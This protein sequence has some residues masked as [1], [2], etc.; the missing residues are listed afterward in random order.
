MNALHVETWW[1]LLVWMLALPVVVALGWRSATALGPAHR[2]LLVLVRVL[3]LGVVAAA[4]TRPALLSRSSEVSVVYALDVSSSVEPGFVEAAIAWMRRTNDQGQPAQARFVAFADRVREADAPESIRQL[5]LRLRGRGPVDG[6]DPLVTDLEGALDAIAGSFS[7]DRLRR[8]VLM[9]DGLETRGD[10]WRAV[11]RLRAANIR[12]FT[13][14]ASVRASSD[15]WVDAL[16]VPRDLRRDEPT[17]VHVRLRAQ[18]ATMARVSLERGERVLGQRRLRLDAGLNRVPFTI[19]LGETGAVSLTAR[20]VAEGDQIGDNDVLTANAT[21]LPRPRVLVIDPTTDSVRYLREALTAQG[22]DVDLAT[23]AGAPDSVE[24]LRPY[25]AVIVSD[26]NG[27]MLGATRMTALATYVRDQGGGLVYAAGANAY[28]EAGLRDSPLERVLPATFEAP[29]KRRDLALVIAL[30]RSYSMKGRKLELAKAATLGALDLLEEEHRFAVITFDSQPEIT[31]PLA[32]VRSKRKAEDL[33]SRFTAS[34]QTN[35]YPALQMA[36][37]MLVDVP[38]KAKHVILLSDG[39]TQPADFQRLARRMGDANITVTTV[40]IGAEADRTLLENIANWGKG[41]HYFAE[42]ADS[43]PQIF[44][45]ETRRLVN[46]GL[47]EDPVQAVVKRRAEALRGIEFG[48]APR[49][50]GVV[51]TKPRERAE[52]YLATDAD[53][54]LLTRWQVG[55]GKAALFGSDLKNRWAAD[56]LT[57]PGYQKFASQLVREVMRRTTREEADFSVSVEGGQVLAR[58]VA[59]TPAGEFR[60]GLTPRVRVGGL[61]GEP[62]EAVMRQAG[63][64]TYELRLPVP[65]GQ[66]GR[67]RFE[68]VGGVPADLR[69]AAGVRELTPPFPDEFRLRAPDSALL[70]ALATET[71]G[72]FSPQPAQVFAS[73]GEAASLRHPAWPWLL[74]TGLLLYLADL[75]LRRSPWVRRRLGG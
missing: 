7:G 6:L 71:G 9:T 28:G 45:Q 46:E 24:G 12:V 65:A 44:L 74:A 13:V 15:V 14:P 40:A 25:D 1:P 11:E 39:D 20:V 70:Q 3:L 75:F 49:L 31:V 37:R 30:D 51:I 47:R 60:N 29:E 16:E 68:L 72:V 66:S 69:S 17:V 34:G 55:L 50:K 48:S 36:Y 38:L 54:A 58:L 4:L 61:P 64:G 19:R 35:M 21:V 23:P 26:A 63:P 42:S 57:W 32:P 53:A 5:P 67:L 41:R 43:V 2:G 10:A 27:E 73:Y 22:F 59:L 62:L 8:V 56:W 18:A 52:V 33:I